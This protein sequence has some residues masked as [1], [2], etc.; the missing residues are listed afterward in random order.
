[1]IQNGQYQVWFKAR[2]GAGLGVVTM[3]NGRVTGGDTMVKYEGTYREEGD[4]FWVTLKTERFA[5]GRLPLFQIDKLDI[6]LHGNSAG[7]IPTASGTVKQVPDTTF[8]VI[9]LPIVDKADSDVSIA[10]R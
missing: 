7:P 1:M 3:E 9:L 8:E 2:Q 4:Q 10:P 6:E 5:P